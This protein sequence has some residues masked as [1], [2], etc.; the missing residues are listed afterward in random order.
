MPTRCLIPLSKIK[1]SFYAS[2]LFLARE[3]GGDVSD[4]FKSRKRDSGGYFQIGGCFLVEV[5]GGEGVF[6]MNFVIN[7]LLRKLSLSHDF[8]V[9]GFL[10]SIFTIG[11]A[12]NFFS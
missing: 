1:H 12:W 8:F 2:F 4:C 5:G 3:G 11:I 6:F 7:V 9:T 10:L